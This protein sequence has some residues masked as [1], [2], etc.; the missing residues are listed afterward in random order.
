MTLILISSGL[1]GVAVL[2][3][4]SSREVS[5][6]EQV[7]RI[8]K[9]FGNVVHYRKRPNLWQK[10]MRNL[11]RDAARANVPFDMAKWSKRIPIIAAVVFGVLLLL[12]LPAWLA[13]TLIVL[14]AMFPR[15]WLRE[16]ANRHVI[17]FRRDFLKEAIQIG[18]H[19]LAKAELED[20]CREIEK[21]ATS[22]AIKREFQ[23]VNQM[24]KA[25]GMTVAEAMI[26]RARELG[27]REYKTLA[28]ATYEGKQRKASLKDVWKDTERNLQRYV[29]AQNAMAAQTGMYRMAAMLLFLGAWGTVA[30]GYRA[31]HPKGVFQIGIAITLV[32]F[33]F[34]VIQIS[35][36]TDAD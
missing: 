30:F 22:K 5:E 8:R 19:A 11:A 6:R 1:L 34:G 32:S 14:L 21:Q 2:L 33:F 17:A 25:P 3:V 7:G 16:I 24:G 26:D 31:M 23:F 35:K 15:Q 27:I 36:S 10:Y 9:W 29:S 20:A 4:F 13:A 12:G 28:I 18:I